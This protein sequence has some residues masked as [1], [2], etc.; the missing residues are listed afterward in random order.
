M[1]SHHT[2]AL[3]VLSLLTGVLMAFVF[4]WTSN[5]RAIKTAK[6]RL[7]ARIL[8]MRIYQD[9]PLLILRAFGG[10]LKS[11]GVYLSKLLRPV[12]FLVPP[13]MIVFMQMDARYSHRPLS[14]GSQT[15]LSV[16]LADGTDPYTTP[17]TLETPP[18]VVAETKPVRVAGPPEVDWRLRITEAGTHTIAVKVAGEAY[19]F[20]LVAGPAYRMIGAARH[21][22]GLMEPLLHP[23]LP[24]IPDQAPIAGVS[25]RYPSA[26]YPLLA[27]NVH[28]I[29]V[30][31]A[32][33]LIAAIALKFII[34][35][36][37]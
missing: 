13:V 35:F 28:W 14:E 34:K 37:F 21:R 16:T 27:W 2:V 6:D 30:F 26:S 3:V 17:I 24:A 4:K 23:A 22:D 29:V 33:S 7:K 9:D 5:P 18:G 10:T 32:Y 15:I 31:L 11:N 1:G 19:T 25:L 36:E 12:I 8:E 20:P